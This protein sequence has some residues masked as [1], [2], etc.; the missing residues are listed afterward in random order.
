MLA[1]LAVGSSSDI[2]Q[3]PHSSQAAVGSEGT[4]EAFPSQIKAI[5]EAFRSGDDA[6][7][8]QLIEGLRL[9]NAG[10]FLG[11]NF[12]PDES[13]HLADRYSR[14]FDG[15]AVSLERTI[16]DVVRHSESEI[17]QTMILG[18]PKLPSQISAHRKLTSLTPQHEQATFRF[19]SALLLHGKQVS[20]WEE[21]Y[22]YRE[23]RFVF[24]GF[25][26]WPIWS[27]EEDGEPRAFPNGHFVIPPELIQKIAPKYPADARKQKIEGTV[28]LKIRIGKDGSVGDIEVIQGDPMLVPAAVE[29]VKKWRYK[30]GTIGDSPYESPVT[31]SVAFSLHAR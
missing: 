14:A 8:H 16:R 20:S 26:G 13:V 25:G 17:V 28:V 12:A 4:E 5:V 3:E 2:A 27:W 10:T 31:V 29:A 18:E 7:G 1:G 15:F 11:E 22:L 6:K 24:I 30:P 9:P 23:G 21:T 19:R